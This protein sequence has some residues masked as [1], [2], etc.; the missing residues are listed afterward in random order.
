[1]VASKKITTANSL[2]EAKKL[3]LRYKKRYELFSKN[4]FGGAMIDGFSRMKGTHL[5][6]I[7]SDLETHPKEVKHMVVELKKND[8]VIMEL[9]DG[10][11]MVVLKAI[12]E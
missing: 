12:I 8:Q 2:K 9:A 4:L 10:S 3:K 6:M 5:L 7:A 11:N 1:M